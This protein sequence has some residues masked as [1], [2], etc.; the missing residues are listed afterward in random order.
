MNAFFAQ[1]K[2]PI[3]S[4][5]PNAISKDAR[6]GSST[7]GMPDLTAATAAPLPGGV[8]AGPSSIAALSLDVPPAPKPAIPRMP[9]TKWVSTS[10]S[11][12]NVVLNSLNIA[13]PRPSSTRVR[14]Q[15]MSKE[16]LE[17]RKRV[18]ALGLEAPRVAPCRNDP[19]A[20]QKKPKATAKTES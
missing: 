10:G 15:D 7:A 9:P 16:E 12:G 3:S 5:C 14:F 6:P 19:H 18:N 1:C 2:Q 11:A 17:C 8:L 4:S 13:V 20:G